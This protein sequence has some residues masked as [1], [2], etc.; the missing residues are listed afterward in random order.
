MKSTWILTQWLEESFL[1]HWEKTKNLHLYQ[2]PVGIGGRKVTT[3]SS[4]SAAR[5]RAS[6]L[7]KNSCL[8]AWP[9]IC[10][11]MDAHIRNPYSVFHVLLSQ[12]NTAMQMCQTVQPHVL[13]SKEIRKIKSIL[14]KQTNANQRWMLYNLMVCL[15]HHPNP[16]MLMKGHKATGWDAH[17]TF[18][19]VADPALRISLRLVLQTCWLL[20]LHIRAINLNS[21]PSRYF[22]YSSLSHIRRR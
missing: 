22:L 18:E 17:Q 10:P 11:S 21:Q 9:M 13:W 16:R 3:R 20:N 6:G 7:F 4:G 2:G 12:L 1:R 15:T 14:L 8:L 19:S 5:L